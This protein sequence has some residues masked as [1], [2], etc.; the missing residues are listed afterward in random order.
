VYLFDLDSY[1]WWASRRFVFPL[2]DSFLA[3]YDDDND[4]DDDDKGEDDWW[5][6]Y[7]PISGT[8]A[9]TDD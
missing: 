1:N 9:K 5:A 8:Q 4:E 7:R 2:L 3:V 6:C